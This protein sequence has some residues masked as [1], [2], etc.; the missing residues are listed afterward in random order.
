[1]GFLLEFGLQAVV[2]ARAWTQSL[3]YLI[4]P[5][6]ASR[7]YVRKRMS[8]AEIKS[9]LEHRRRNALPWHYP[10]RYDQG[11]RHYM[12]TAACY[13]HLPVVGKR[14]VRL[15]DCAQSL[16][17]AIESGVDSSIRAWVILPN[18]YHLLVFSPDILALLKH[19]GR[20]HG[21]LSRKWNL[22]DGLVGRKIWHGAV[23]TAIK[24]DRHHHAVVN[25]IHHN[26]V[27]HGYVARWQD[28]LASSA[29][30]YL[31]SVGYDEAAR[32][33]KLYPVERFGE[34]WD[35]SNI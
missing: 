26:P 31:E 17:G 27:K 19:L 34:G 6:K 11:A 20:V 29:H 28:W 5:I 30:A 32:R 33:W 22:E 18:H 2:I 21:R 4:Q 8:E 10:P 14:A 9:L 25:Y 1:M 15:L 7:M 16:L 35:D 13:Q 24:S 3:A 12:I 23:E